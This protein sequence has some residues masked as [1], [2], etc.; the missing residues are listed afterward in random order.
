MLCKSTV[1]TD[2]TEKELVATQLCAKVARNKLVSG[3]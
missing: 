1:T 2:K 3:M